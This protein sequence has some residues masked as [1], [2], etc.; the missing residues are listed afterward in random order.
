[1]GILGFFV[2]LIALSVFVLFGMPI[3]LS[4]IIST[5]LLVLVS[6][7]PLVE[8]MTGTY[9]AGVGGFVTS[10]FLL[11]L[12]GA[13]FGKIIE[14]SGAT[15]SIARTIVKK[16]GDKWV[17]PAL[18]VVCNIMVY[19]GVNLYVAFFTL[20]PI[21]MSVFRACDL[22]RRLW[23]G[24][25]VAGVGTYAMTGPFTPSIQN[26]V[27]TKYLGT[28]VAAGWQVGLIACIPFAIAVIFYEYKSGQR[29]KKR[30]EHFV[31]LDTDKFYD[32]NTDKKLPGVLRSV[33]P[34][35]CL[36]IF[37]NAFGMTAE[38]AMVLASLVAIVVFFPYLPHKKQ[39]IFENLSSAISNSA[40]T[41]INPAV[42][43]GF[44]SVAITTAAYAQLTDMVLNLGWD[45]F[46]TAAVSAGVLACMSGSCTAG[47]GITFP[48]VW[49][50][51]GSTGIDPATL[52]RIATMGAG[53]IDSLPSS[54]GTSTWLVATKV[55]Y[56]EG[57]FD[58]F[59]TSVVMPTGAVAIAIVAAYLLGFAYV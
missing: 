33:I 14:M 39:E 53:T 17:I 7:M 5:I 12:L 35:L 28:T 15:E 59:I 55:S 54:G 2:C 40:I 47:L 32:E 23:P 16:A 38:V 22:P 3:A 29:A 4:A 52:H 11:F 36:I 57:Y 50:M 13:I 34:M 48:V 41:T 20:T 27:G 19:G 1:M 46:V 49:N 58:I 51:F 18:I 45:P 30:G 26:L 43:V 6:G 25:Y 21:V 9:M 10:Y 56:R 31:A 37:L 24:V 44:G 8:T 42:T